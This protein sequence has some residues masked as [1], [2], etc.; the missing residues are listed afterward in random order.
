MG[1]IRI[2]GLLSESQMQLRFFKVTNARWNVLNDYGL[3]EYKQIGNDK[4][5]AARWN[6]NNKKKK[7]TNTKS[8]ISCILMN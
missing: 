7:I 4:R 1:I 3:H 5:N 2:D 6:N 8:G